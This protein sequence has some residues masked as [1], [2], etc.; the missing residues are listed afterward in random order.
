MEDAATVSHEALN[1]L[2]ARSEEEMELFQV[3]FLPPYESP[4]GR[5]VGYVLHACSSRPPGWIR[6]ARLQ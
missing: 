5:L 3:R 6:P 2:L 4:V 1:E